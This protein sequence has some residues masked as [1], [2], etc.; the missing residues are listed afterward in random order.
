MPGAAS[1]DLAGERVLLHSRL[2]GAVARFTGTET[3]SKCGGGGTNVTVL[4][5]APGQMENSTEKLR[6]SC[7]KC[8][9]QWMVD[10]LDF[11]G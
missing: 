6:L 5:L 1:D 11:V 7:G 4:F 8:G 10:P 9:Y 2:G 3:C